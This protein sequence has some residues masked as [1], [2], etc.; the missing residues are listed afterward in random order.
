MSETAG[1]AHVHNPNSLSPHPPTLSLY[2]ILYYIAST[3]SRQP[4]P[5]PAQLPAPP[6]KT[7]PTERSASRCSYGLCPSPA[8]LPP[9]SRSRHRPLCAPPR[10]QRTRAPGGSRSQ[11]PAR[12]HAPARR[13]PSA[14]AQNRSQTDRQTPLRVSEEPAPLSTNLPCRAHVLPHTLPHCWGCV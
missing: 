14:C 4:L 10:A 2:N 8:E 7:A 12:N 6:W 11:R 3:T 1:L 13:L 5:Q 9:P